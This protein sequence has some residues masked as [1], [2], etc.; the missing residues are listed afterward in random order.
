MH[1]EQGYSALHA[2]DPLL[3]LCTDHA[4]FVPSWN[5]RECRSTEVGHIAYRD[6]Y[7]ALITRGAESLYPIISFH[8]IQ[9]IY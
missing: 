7:P 1:S 5:V 4:P 3:R 9:R 6:H 8:C 2:C